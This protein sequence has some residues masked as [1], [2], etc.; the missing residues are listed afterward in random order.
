MGQYK[1]EGTVFVNVLDVCSRADGRA[2]AVAGVIVASIEFVHNECCAVTA[3]VLN[4]GELG[5]GDDLARGVS[6]VAC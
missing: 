6:W 4:L 5:V 1:G 3:Y 2:V